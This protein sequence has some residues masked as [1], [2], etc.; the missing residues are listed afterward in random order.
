MKNLLAACAV[1]ICF[2][3]V[4]I[5]FAEIMANPTYEPPGPA[6]SPSWKR[7]APG[8]HGA[9]G[10]IDNR[11]ER[12]TPPELRDT[13]LWTDAAWRGERACAQIVLW[14]ADGAQQVR[15]KTSPLQASNA[16]TIPAAAVTARFVRYVLADGKL[17]GDILDT[18]DRLDTPAQTTRP[19]W[20]SIDVPRQTTP[21]LYKGSVEV[22][23]KDRPTLTFDLNL[24]VLPMTLPKPS[25]WYFHLDLWQ[26]P[27]AV[28]RYHHVRPWSEQ[29]FRLLRPH[30]KMLADAGQKCL[31]TTIVYRPWGTQTYDPHDS[32]VGWIRR[33]DGS[34]TYDYS[35]FDKYVSFGQKCGITNQINCYSM[36]PWTKTFRYYDEQT[37]NYELLKAQAGTAEYEKLWRPFLR[38][39][40]AHL[41]EKAWLEK[42]T[43][44]MDE[45]PLETMQK[46][47]TLV[48]QTTPELK[49]ALAVNYQPKVKIDIYDLS[50]AIGH[51]LEP[52]FV[53]QRIIQSRPTT[54][55]VCCG[56]ARPN[57]FLCS[58]PAESTWMGF[59]AAA[60]KYSG[61]LRWAYDSWVADPLYDTSHVNWTAGDCFL[62]YPGPRSSIRF[63]RLREG[64]AH[65]EKIRILRQAAQKTNTTRARNALKQINEMLTTFNFKAAQKTPAAN[66]VNN[67][68]KILT[69]LSR[70]PALQ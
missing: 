18:I 7:I 14:T 54:F 69:Q 51:P 44:A 22:L 38:D 58:P 25:E 8:L 23:A 59:Y 47:I 28:A 43:I 11:Y 62:V 34:F 60:R 65:Y 27:F 2:A 35:I 10:S 46:V 31:T 41:R 45:R 42:T 32:M 5:S 68:K 29:H 33:P 52:H 9:F 49:L 36:V 3:P 4:N 50:A 6:P 13:K 61:F 40:V 15:I 30:L 24:E 70:N 1:V 55:Y 17:I 48:K 12:Q 20:L 53:Q 21:G 56:P 16:T 66:S 39:F 64:I 19:I 57:T 37:G 67:A 26:N 63:E